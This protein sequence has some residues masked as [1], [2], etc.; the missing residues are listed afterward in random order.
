MKLAYFSVK[1]GVIKEYLVYVE[2][3]INGYEVN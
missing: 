3:D 2:F 1:F